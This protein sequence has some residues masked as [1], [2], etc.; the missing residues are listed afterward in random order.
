MLLTETSSAGFVR[1]TDTRELVDRLQ[2][3]GNLPDLV[4]GSSRWHIEAA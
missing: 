3:I 4:V 2:R 1:D